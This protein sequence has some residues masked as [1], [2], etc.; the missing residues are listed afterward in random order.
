MIKSEL[1][2]LDEARE[3]LHEMEAAQRHR[4]VSPA[5]LVNLNLVPVGRSCY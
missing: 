1:G 4:F 5:A 2:S 3:L